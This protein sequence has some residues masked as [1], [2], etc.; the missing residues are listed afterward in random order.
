MEYRQNEIVYRG[1]VRLGQGLIALLRAR[2]NYDGLQNLPPDTPAGE[3]RRWFRKATPGTSAVI[4][5]SHTSLLD[6]VFA[7]WTI[8]RAQGTHVRYMI[9]LKW[10]NNEFMRAINGW[11]GHIPVN[12]A[13]GAAAYQDAKAK[14]ERGEWVGIFPEGSRN[15]AI[16][17]HRL[18]TGAVR[19]A[20]ETG[21][22]V[23][24][25]AVFGGQRILGGGARFKLRNLWRAPVSVVIGVPLYVGPD[26]DV[27][28]ANARLQQALSDTVDR[29][30][31]LF[32]AEIPP[33]AA[34]M[35]ADRGG[36]APTVAEAEAAW[37]ARRAERE[38]LG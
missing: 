24:P 17:P 15:R 11:C 25:V 5:I 26:E 14:L 1:I 28:E 13:A 36:S 27:Q 37:E 12:R 18:R 31:D 33:G 8:Y 22:P 34:W 16:R 21:S 6:F 38:K 3:K 19:L 23:V 2:V 30:I 10:A 4:A 9:A 7:Q 20:Q 35:P 29:A 32:P